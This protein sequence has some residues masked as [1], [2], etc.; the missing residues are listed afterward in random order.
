MP[1]TPRLAAARALLALALLGPASP[2]V[3]AVSPTAVTVPL[4]L[5]CDLSQPATSRRLARDASGSVWLA[6]QCTGQVVVT[7]TQ[8]G[9]VTWRPAVVVW[10][11]AVTQV[12]I[13][14]GTL[15]GHAIVAWETFVDVIMGSSTTDFGA[16]WSPPASLIVSST[17]TSGMSIVAEGPRYHV[18]SWSAFRNVA[19]VR[20]SPDRGMSWNPEVTASMP[21]AFGDLVHDP[22]SG[23]LLLVSDSPA[24]FQRTSSDGGASFAPTAPLP[25]ACCLTSSDWAVGGSRLLFGVGGGTQLWRIDLGAASAVALPGLPGT[26]PAQRSVDAD[27]AGTAYTSGREQPGGAIRLHR[28]PSSALVAPPGV[29]LDTAGDSPATQACETGSAAVAWRS[30]DG[31][32]LFD[33]TC[34]DGSWTCCEAELDEPPACEASAPPGVECGGS[35]TVVPL[36]GSGSRDPEGNALAFAWSTTCPGGIF[37]DPASPSPELLVDASGLCDL[38]CGVTLSVSDGAQSSACFASIVIRDTTPPVVAASSRVIATLWPPN[39][40]LV[41]LGEAELAPSVS[42]ACAPAAAWSVAS[43]DCDQPDDALGDGE[44]EDDCVVSPDGRSVLVRAERDGARP[45]GRTCSVL[46]RA[47]DPC[48]NAASATLIG[49]VHIPRDRSP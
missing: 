41:R 10:P 18:M 11:A 48:G 43:C 1:A 29:L 14:G 20:T 44:T 33:K 30:S 3:A 24:L 17:A 16:T 12:S 39:H 36:D 7:V 45:E 5:P 15:P 34:E 28:I 37:D 8:D 22:S 6:A 32:I 47:V 42:D 25:G 49:L 26:F 4:P 19:A 21:W 2:S 35:A 31:R 23:E 40:R 46:A 9:G 13:E 27:A 38:T